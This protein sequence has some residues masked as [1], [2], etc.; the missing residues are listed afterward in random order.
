MEPITVYGRLL[1]LL[2]N[3][4]LGWRAMS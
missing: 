1:L 3:F 2:T 4:T